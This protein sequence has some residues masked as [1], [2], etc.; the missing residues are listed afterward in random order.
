MMY[1]EDVKV[2]H[3]VFIPVFTSRDDNFEGGREDDTEERWEGESKQRFHLKVTGR[4]VGGVWIV[5]CRLK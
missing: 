3:K 1:K 5:S 2:E 4:V